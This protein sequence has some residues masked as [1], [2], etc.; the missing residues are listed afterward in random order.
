MQNIH[1]KLMNFYIDGK[2]IVPNSQTKQ[3]LINPATENSV[4]Q[5]TL[6]DEVDVENAVASATTAFESFQHF[7]KKDRLD[8]LKNILS[9]YER[10]VDEFASAISIEMGAPMDFARSAQAQAGIDHLSALIED[11]EDYDFCLLYT[12]DAADE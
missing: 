2:W 1:D 7:S 11:T 5:I 4:G 6:A 10:R 8:L 3:S 12:S 9:I